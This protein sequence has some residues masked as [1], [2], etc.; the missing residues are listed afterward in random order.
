M[1]A[2]DVL[3]QMPLFEQNSKIK[4]LYFCSSLGPWLCV[5]LFH[6]V[7]MCILW[8][9]GLA[10]FIGSSG[11][12]SKRYIGKSVALHRSC[13]SDA[14]MF[15][16]HAG[17]MRGANERDRGLRH[18]REALRL[19]NWV[20]QRWVQNLAANIKQQ[21]EQSCDTERDSG[22]KWWWEQ[23][24]KSRRACAGLGFDAEEQFSIG[25]TEE[26]RAWC[27]FFFSPY[28]SLLCPDKA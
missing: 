12:N 8:F 13:I 9:S 3:F 10:E 2:R 5:C 24:K 16:Y 17:T 7:H 4:A 6:L 21:N 19:W 26:Q 27:L 28:C 22:S 1:K 23:Q 15:S 14:E 11:S 25:E 20:Y 18:T